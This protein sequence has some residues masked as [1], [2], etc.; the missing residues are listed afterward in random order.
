MKM[1]WLGHSAFMLEDQNALILIDPF[2]KGNP[3]FPQELWGKAKKA[4]AILVTHGH[5]D[6]LG[7]TVELAKASGAKVLTSFEL[8]HYLRQKGIEDKNIVG[9]NIGG[10]VPLPACTVHMVQAIHSNSIMDGDDIIY[11]G[12]PS[13]FVIEWGASRIYHAGDTALFSDMGLIQ[14]FYKPTVGLL[15]IGGHYTMTPIAAAYACN[16]LLDL[17][18]IVPMHHNTFPVIATDVQSFSAMVTRGKVKSLTAGES[19]EVP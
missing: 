5:G 8:G 12:Y 9:M 18:I 19:I 13:G 17:E 10:A 4:N 1:T 11:A 6:H 2:L 16:N 14:S 7:D 15:P 3:Q